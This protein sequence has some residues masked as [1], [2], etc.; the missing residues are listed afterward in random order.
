MLSSSVVSEVLIMPMCHGMDLEAV[1]VNHVTAV[2]VRDETLGAELRKHPQGK[3]SHVLI[4]SH[5]TAIFKSSLRKVI[6]N[7]H[8]V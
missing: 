5:S 3:Q 4:L 8:I 7:F 6:S 1:P 2:T